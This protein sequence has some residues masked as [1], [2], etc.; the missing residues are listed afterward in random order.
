LD[1]GGRKDSRT[2]G[3][4]NGNANSK[5]KAIWLPQ[6]VVIP[7][8][9]DGVLQRARIRRL[10]P[11][12]HNPK[13]G[14][15]YCVVSGSSTEAMIP[16]DICKVLVV[17]ESEFDAILL[18]QEAGHL[19]GII[20]LG[21]AQTRHDKR[22]ADLLRAADLILVSLDSDEHRGDG[23]NPGAKEAWG[24]WLKHFEQARRLPPID[25][26]DPGEMWKAGVDL[27][28]WVRIGI[29]KYQRKD[30]GTMVQEIGV[31]ENNSQPLDS[32]VPTLEA[33]NSPLDNAVQVST[34]TGQPSEQTGIG[35]QLMVA[36]TTKLEDIASKC[37]DGCHEW[38]QE[39][40][41]ELYKGISSDDD[42]LNEVW[43]LCLVGRAAIRNFQSALDIWYEGWMEAIYSYHLHQQNQQ[44][45]LDPDRL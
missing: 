38:V 41:P 33:I 3:K 44:S 19:A 4:T 21:S 20:A 40:M 37:P 22:S 6:G 2:N 14:P 8:Y 26:K 31:Q 42:W 34:S 35:D 25:G 36:Y 18:N 30:S 7:Y 23:K 32:T 27:S 10:D 17:V 9:A 15:P 45:L 29:E 1:R 43:K 24:W 5:S 28:E 16:E 13:K 39:N 12:G 11:H